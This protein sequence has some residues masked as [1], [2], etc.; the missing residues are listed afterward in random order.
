M[1]PGALCDWQGPW[2]GK[3]RAGKQPGVGARTPEQQC[4][5]GAVDVVTAS[6][7]F[8][9]ALSVIGLV[10]SLE[11]ARRECG[12]GAP[13]GW[14]GSLVEQGGRS[15]WCSPQR[16]GEGETPEMGGM[17]NTTAGPPSRLEGSG[18]Q[19]PSATRSEGRA[20]KDDK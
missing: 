17:E 4:T 8:T 7:G 19:P 6:M 12:A 20:Q 11:M 2:Q 15:A 14:R 13:W 1:L 16:W 9:V 10:L 18:D 5:R 3:R